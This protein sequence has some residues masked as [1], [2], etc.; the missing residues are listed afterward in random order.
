M[1]IFYHVAYIKIFSISK[2]ICYC[3]TTWVIG[4]AIDIPNF[5]GFG[6]HVYDTKAL[7][8]VFDRLKIAYT[9]TFCIVCI[10]IPTLFILYCYCRIFFYSYTIRKK[11]ADKA[12]TLKNNA[13]AIKMAKSLFAAFFIFAVC[14]I[15]VSIILMVGAD[16]SLPMSAHA[17][18]NLPA[19]LNSVVNPLSYAIFNSKMREGYKIFLNKMFLDKIYKSKRRT[20]SKA[21]Q[22]QTQA[23]TT[24]DTQTTRSLERLVLYFKFF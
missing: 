20:K 14:W 19:H 24:Q 9:A 6:D 12:K 13:D 11:I 22:T 1:C 7:A 23:T 4:L 3:V 18:T 2:T 21:E 15:P 16:D 10:Y 17:F 5:F 8:C